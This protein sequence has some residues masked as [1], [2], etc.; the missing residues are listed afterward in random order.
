MLCLCTKQHNRGSCAHRMFFPGLDIVQ[1]NR[2]KAVYSN[3]EHKNEMYKILWSFYGLWLIRLECCW[4]WFF[5]MVRGLM[6]IPHPHNNSN[7]IRDSA[8]SAGLGGDS[9]SMSVLLSVSKQNISSQHCSHSNLWLQPF[10]S[11]LFLG[12]FL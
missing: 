2:N 10:N 8:E 4:W 9:K 3:L 11:S 1:Y 6:I 5:F 7:Y 12:I